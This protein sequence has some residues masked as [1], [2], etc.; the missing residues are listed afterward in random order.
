MS[1]PRTSFIHTSDRGCGVV[2]PLI[3][4]DDAA[5]EVSE[6]SGLDLN[7]KSAAPRLPAWP[8]TAVLP[9]L[10]PTCLTSPFGWEAVS[11]ADMAALKAG[12]ETR[13]LIVRRH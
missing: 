3:Q 8:P 12:P 11:Q 7:A 9:P 1:D 5:A 4:C 13:S 2:L 6:L 10:E